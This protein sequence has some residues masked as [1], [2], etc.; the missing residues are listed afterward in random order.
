MKVF[1]LEVIHLT[2]EILIFPILLY[3]KDIEYENGLHLLEKNLQ[4]A[5]VSQFSHSVMSDSLWPHWLQH[6]R[7]PGPSPT[8]GVYSNSCPLSHWMSHPMSPLD[9]DAIQPSHLLFSPSSAFQSFPASGSFQMS[10]LFTSSGQS[11]GVSAST[12]V[13]PM[14]IHDWFPLGWTG[15]VFL[16]SKGLSGVFSNTILQKHQFFGAQL[17]L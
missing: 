16:Q 17:S 9:G 8:P 15:W 7:P 4:K 2:I 10:Q 6:T 5:S 13:F 12:S 1:G 3:D 11:I 14:S